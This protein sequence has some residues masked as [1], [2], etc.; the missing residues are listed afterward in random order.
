[1]RLALTVF[2]AGSGADDFENYGGVRKAYATVQISGVKEQANAYLTT[3]LFDDAGDLAG[4]N[5][6]DI[7]RAHVTNF[8]GGTNAHYVALLPHHNPSAIRQMRQEV[9]QNTRIKVEAAE[10][11]ITVT[12]LLPGDHLR[13]FTSAGMI[14]FSKKYQGSRQFVPLQAHDVYLLST[15]QE[16][17]KYS[18]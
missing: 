9:K 7:Q 18:Y 12:G 10:G 4:T 13:A 16:V 5:D 8:S 3:H 11:G 2:R 17:V 14:V 1:M 15:G 6:A